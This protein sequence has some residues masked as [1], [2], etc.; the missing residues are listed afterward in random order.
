[1][2]DAVS[3]IKS[4]EQ[5]STPGNDCIVAVTVDEHDVQDIPPID[6]TASDNIIG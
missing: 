3:P 4:T 5:R 6:R 2:I 1:M